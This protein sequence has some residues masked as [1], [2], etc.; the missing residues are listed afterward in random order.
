[1]KIKSIISLAVLLL[2]IAGCMTDQ[3][4]NPNSSDPRDKF[5]GDWKVTE[6]CSRMNYNVN[7]SY[8]PQN[9]AQVL[10]TNFG[11]PGS[12]Y[13]PAVA[14]VTGN[15]IYVSSQ[16]IG[17]GWS[18]SGSGTMNDSGKINW[19]YDLVIN[20]SGQSCTATYSR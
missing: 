4:T 17:S 3:T 12:G 14:L 18:V 6:T 19:S 9:S 2:M 20:G 16:T 7:I 10:I 15:T 11:N 1:M 5:L 13:S 8:D